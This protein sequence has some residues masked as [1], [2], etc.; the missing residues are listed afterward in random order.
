MELFVGQSSN[1]HVEL[2]VPYLLWDLLW[3]ETISV[4]PLQGINAVY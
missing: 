3:I 2:T 4:N 1:R